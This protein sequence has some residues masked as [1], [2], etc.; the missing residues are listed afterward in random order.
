MKDFITLAKNVRGMKRC[1]DEVLQVT[2]IA[3]GSANRRGHG[4]ANFPTFL[5][6][7]QCVVDFT[8]FFKLCFEVSSFAKIV[9]FDPVIKIHER[10]NGAR[11]DDESVD[12]LGNLRMS[13][14]LVDFKAAV[15]MIEEEDPGNEV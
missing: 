15:V 4:P 7:P 14:D 10:L 5:V 3:E 11:V 13:E 6:D 2:A 12:V 8:F 1:K 9:T